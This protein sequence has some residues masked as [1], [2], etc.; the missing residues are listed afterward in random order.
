MDK[1]VIVLGGGIAGLSVSIYL[2]EKGYEVTIIEKNKDVGGLCYGYFEDGYYIDA[3]LHWLMGTNKQ[4]TLYKEWVKVGA[5][6][7]STKFISLPTLGT[8]EYEGTKVTFYRNLDKTEKELIKISPEDKKA[9]HR[10]IS[11]VRDMGSLMGLLMKNKKLRSLKPEELLSSFPTY[12]HIMASMKLSRKQYAEKFSHPAL[13]F[14]IENAMTGYNNMFFFLDFY[15][16]FSNGNADL[17]VGGAYYMVERIKNKFLSLGGK[18]VTNT[19]V[20]KIVTKFNRVIRIETDKGIYEGDHYIS[21]I[22]PK[23]T[24]DVLMDGK[25][26]IPLF[27]RLAKT[28]NKRSISSC[29]NLYIAVD[30]DVSGIDAPT[31]IQTKPMKV[32]A[33]EVSALLVRPYHYDP[34]HFVKDGKTVVLLFIDQNQDDYAYYQGLSEDDYKKERKRI[35]EDMLKAFLDRYPQYEGKVKTLMFFGP[36]EIHEQTNTSFGS[37]QSYSFTDKGMFYMFPGRLTMVGNLSLCGQW[38][39]AIGGTPTALLT[40]GELAKTFMRVKRDNDK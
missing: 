40:A 38:T 8:F 6:D 23:Y 14:A 21:T 22:D 27:N 31:V 25:V 4:S 37:I 3:C 2:L 33:K 12:G 10:F 19:T 24:M 35:E 5:F 18:L 15:G 32:G 11:S 26:K 29:V 34:E 7:K 39:R 20:K 28:V 36:K 1:Q 30:G 9:I 16:L 17:P 13:R